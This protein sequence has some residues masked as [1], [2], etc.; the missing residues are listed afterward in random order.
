MAVDQFLAHIEK[1]RRVSPHTLRAYRT[2]LQEFLEFAQGAGVGWERVDTHQVRS[3]LHGL[4]GRRKPATI[5]RKLAALRSFY[6][7][8]VASERLKKS[9]CEGV[10]S[11]KNPKRT[12]QVLEAEEVSRMLERTA[13]GGENDAFRLRDAALLEILYAG[14]LRVSELVGLNELDVDHDARVLRVRGK[15]RKER[16]V[17]VG[18]PAI[19]AL[20]NYLAVRAGFGPDAHEPAL[21]LN[22]FGRRLSDRS[23]RTVLSRRHFDAGG[24]DSVHPHALRHS[25][26]THLLD[27][28]AELR[29][30][31]EYLGHESLATTQRYTQVSLE[32]L[33]RVYDEAHPRAKTQPDEE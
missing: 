22:R 27:A 10:R 16:I 25:A 18:V 30:I 31:Q 17:P 26:A 32:R 29:H 19:E 12:P 33:M 14:G 28:G 20:N 3:Y 21:F 4:Y 5:A 6:R 24:W 15:G 7:W 8:A 23:V 1:V 9:P 11:P 13:R 2:D